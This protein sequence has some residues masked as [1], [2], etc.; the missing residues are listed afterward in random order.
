MKF[1]LATALVVAASAADKTDAEYTV[2]GT[3]EA[4]NMLDEAK[5]EERSASTNWV[6]RN[7][8]KVK[9]VYICLGKRKDG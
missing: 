2:I 4:R 5:R 9:K 1:A 7:R 6:S 3:L 8:D